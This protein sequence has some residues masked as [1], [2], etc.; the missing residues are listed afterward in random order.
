M[1]DNDK[2]SMQYIRES[3]IKGDGNKLTK[4]QYKDA[5]IFEKERL[6]QQLIFLTFVSFLVGLILFVSLYI[7]I[8]E[9][10]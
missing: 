3:L 5:V 4:A 1:S 6:F 8:K 7:D 9:S 2:K 10:A